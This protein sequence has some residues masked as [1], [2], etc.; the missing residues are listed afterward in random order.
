MKSTQNDSRLSLLD[1]DLCK[2]Q[3]SYSL[4]LGNAVISIRYCSEQLR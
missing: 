3:A 2:R 4:D 1:T